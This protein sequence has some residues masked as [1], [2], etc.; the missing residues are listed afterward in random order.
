MSLVDLGKRLL[1][2]ARKG[3]DDEVRTLM[4]NGAPFTTDWLGTSPLHL[5]AQYGHYSTAEVLL[6]AG[7]SRDARTKV[8]R[9]PL[10][11]AAADGHAHIV[12]LL[13]RNG[14]DVNAKDMLKMTALHWATEHHHR[15]VVE[16]LIKYG[17]DVHAF[18]KFDKSAFDI[19]LEKNNAEILVILQ[20]AMQNQVNANPE[21]ANPV[22]M[23][24]PFIFTSGEVVNLASLVSSAS[25][26]T[27]SANSEEI[28][29][30]N[31][32]DSSI[33]QVVGSGG[34]RVITIVTDG[35]PLGNIQTAIPTG[36]I[37]Q[38]FIVTMQDGQQVLTVPAGQVAEETVIEE[39]AEEA[40]KLPLTK[41]PR[42]E[43]MTDS[44]EESK[45]GTERELLQQQLQEANRRAQEYRHQLLKKEQE[46][47]QYR[48]KLEAM[49]RQQPNGVDFTMVEEVAEVDAVVVTEGEMEE[50]E[51]EVTGAVGTTEPHTGVSMETVST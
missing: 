6:R 34:Q 48:L 15:D 38:P 29:E 26:K 20:E 37:G 12:E 1:E 28:I 3:Q 51:T 43:E 32:V 7:V 23:G 16:L 24:T 8:D 22:T 46:A 35:V 50:R 45:E 47:E 49:A 21:R 9:T 4:A 13:V 44:V 11:M 40:E 33:Q 42:I 5:A 31:S 2:A 30:G 27:T 19:A 25:T 41:K 17:A 39:E 36:G 10:H 18:S 14:A